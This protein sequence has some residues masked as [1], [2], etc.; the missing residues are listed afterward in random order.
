M[1]SLKVGADLAYVFCADEAALPIKCYSPELMVASVYSGKDF[2]KAVAAA[3]QNNEDVDSHDAKQQQRQQQQQQLVDDMVHEVTSMMDSLHALVVGPGL[4]RCPLVFRAVARILQEAQ[5]KY[6]LPLVLDADALFMLS[7]PEYKELLTN[8]SIVVLTPN[9]VEKKRL[10]ESGVVLPDHCVVL[11][12]GG[13]DKIQP[14]NND[15]QSLECNELGG[16]KRSGGIGD[17]LAGTT[18][19]LLA[20][21]RILTQRHE[22]SPQNVPLACWTACCFV[23]RA[24]KRAFDI[25]R[26]SMTAPDVLDALGPAIDDMTKKTIQD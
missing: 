18:G 20:W 4:G 25:H 23:K 14:L 15:W 3:T 26:R 24:A 7:Q 10:D 22:T 5:S 2:D 13:I 6:H 12:K 9:V 1:A 8:D 17:V 19:T 21:N 11:E 16:L